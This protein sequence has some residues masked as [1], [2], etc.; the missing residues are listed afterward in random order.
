MVSKATNI[1]S[2]SN[3]PRKRRAESFYL[4]S[5]RCDWNGYLKIRLDTLCLSH[6]AMLIGEN[7]LCE[8]IGQILEKSGEIIVRHSCARNRVEYKVKHRR[9]IVGLSTLLKTV[10]FQ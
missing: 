1:Q 7:H 6:N 4:F 5:L 8:F 3:E 9:T 2:Y 10:T